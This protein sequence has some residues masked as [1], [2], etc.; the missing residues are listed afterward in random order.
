MFVDKSVTTE[1]FSDTS[2]VLT[3]GGNYISAFGGDVKEFL[4]V[5]VGTLDHVNYV[6]LE[7]S[8]DRNTWRSLAAVDLHMPMRKPKP[9]P[10]P[11]FR[12]VERYLR[13]RLVDDGSAITGEAVVTV[14]ETAQGGR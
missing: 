4:L 5:P 8:P 12:H 14:A 9:I 2:E 10:I 6:L 3:V 13:F 7:D 11:R 1:P